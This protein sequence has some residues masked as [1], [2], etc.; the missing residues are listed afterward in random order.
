MAAQGTLSLNMTAN[1]ERMRVTIAKPKTQ[2]PIVGDK[3]Q[4]ISLSCN[5]TGDS[6]ELEKIVVGVCYSVSSLKAND[7]VSE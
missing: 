5:F 3:N 7:F 1:V 6:S 4:K 2:K